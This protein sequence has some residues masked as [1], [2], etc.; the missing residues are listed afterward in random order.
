VELP[1]GP[2]EVTLQSSRCWAPAVSV[3]GDSG[4]LPLWPAASISGTIDAG[5]H[6][7]GPL[8][9]EYQLPEIGDPSHL[10]WLSAECSITNSQ[11]SCPAP[12]AAF[13]LRLTVPQYAPH[14]VPRVNI[15]GGERKDVGSIHFDRG[16]S[17]AGVVL[18]AAGRHDRTVVELAAAAT[19]K[20]KPRRIELNDAADGLFQFTALPPDTYRLSV[21]CAGCFPAEVSAIRVEPPSGCGSRPPILRHGPGSSGM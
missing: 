10:Q 1:G 13:R 8:R 21:R 9:A 7:A 20:A 5:N 6:V 18:T 4:I 12:A 16:A 17:V 2:W 11:W 3:N 15:A 14:Y 19:P